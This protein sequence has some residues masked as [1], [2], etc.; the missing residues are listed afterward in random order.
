MASLQAEQAECGSYDVTRTVDSFRC[1]DCELDAHSDVAGTHHGWGVLAVERIR[2][3][4]RR[5]WGTVVFS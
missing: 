5:F 3:D 2:L 1:Q 4:T